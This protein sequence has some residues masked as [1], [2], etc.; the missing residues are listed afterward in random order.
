MNSRLRV[1]LV[2]LVTLSASASQ[3]EPMKLS[4]LTDRASLVVIG[5]VVGSKTTPDTRGFT[6]TIVTVKIA[7]VMKGAYAR[8]YL[9]IRTRSGLVF[10]DRHLAVGDG[11]VLFLKSST[12]DAFEA[13]YPGSFALFQQGTF[14]TA[15]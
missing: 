6:E 3:I 12:N 8:P 4:E 1:F 14:T 9:R 5:T 11:G 7:K 2:A 15:K 10:F 13:A